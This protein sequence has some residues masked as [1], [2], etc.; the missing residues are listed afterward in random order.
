M[1][2]TK[3]LKRINQRINA[4]SMVSSKISEDKKKEIDQIFTNK[5]GQCQMLAEGV[6]TFLVRVGSI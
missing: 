6:K 5:I 4:Y 3:H 2:N 1:Q